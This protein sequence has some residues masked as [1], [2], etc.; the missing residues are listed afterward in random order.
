MVYLLL[1]VP[2]LNN[3]FLILLEIQK[4]YQQN[5]DLIGWITIEDTK[6]DYPVMFTKGEDYYLRRDFYKK[7]VQAVHFILINIKQWN[8]EISIL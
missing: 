1:L 7:K 8:Q 6:I 3:Y 4:L 2:I 5:N